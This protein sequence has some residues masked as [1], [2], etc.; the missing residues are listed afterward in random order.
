[1]S[2]SLSAV[3][4]IDLNDYHPA[5]HRPAPVVNGRPV[6]FDDTTAPVE[7]VG[8]M[9]ICHACLPDIVVVLAWNGHRY[10]VAN[11]RFPGE[12]R[13]KARFYQRKLTR[14]KLDLSSAIGYYVS[15]AQIGRGR[16][17]RRWLIAHLAHHEWLEFLGDT[18]RLDMQ[19]ARIPMLFA[20]F[21]S[22]YINASSGYQYFDDTKLPPRHGAD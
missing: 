1:M 8:D 20:T 10:Q 5:E 4:G 17:A 6:L 13:R 15:S 2:V 9:P 7:F 21:Q 12:S 22:H 16:A 14:N 3:G 18:W 19:V 11:L